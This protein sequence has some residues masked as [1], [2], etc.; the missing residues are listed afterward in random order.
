MVA[1][2][3]RVIVGAR[4]GEDVLVVQS[5]DGRTFVPLRGLR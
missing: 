4:D 2:D 1:G 3:D 5:A